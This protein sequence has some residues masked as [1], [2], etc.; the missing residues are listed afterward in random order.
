MK[1]RILTSALALC[2]V[3]S[4]SVPAMAA[5]ATVPE[6]TDMSITHNGSP[7]N[8]DVVNGSYIFCDC[9]ALPAERSIL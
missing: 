6:V 2:M 1:K 7:V 8:R 4:L 5:E 3:L 9:T